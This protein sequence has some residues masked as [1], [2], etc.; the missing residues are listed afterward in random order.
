MSNHLLFFGTE[1]F[2]AVSLQALIDAGFSIATVVTK[3]DFR[4]GRKQLLTQPVVKKI[5]LAHNIPVLQP[6]KLTD[7]SEDLRALQPITGVLVSYGKIIPESIIN[8]CSPGIINV[9]PS[10]LPKYRGASPIESAI[11]HGDGKT[12]VSLMKLV[13]AM[14]AG[15]VYVQESVSLNGDENRP[16][17]YT[18]LAIVGSRLLINNLQKIIN[19]EILP[20][21]QD[22]SKAT[23]TQL[24]KKE[25]GILSPSVKTAVQLEREV[26]AYQGYP[27]C[28]YTIYNE[29][30]IVL[31]SR[32]A[33]DEED[34]QLIVACKDNT[35]LELLSLTGP[36]GRVMSGADFVRGYRK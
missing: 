7:I 15:P 26:R 27:K 25:D 20:V 11:L 34:G 13:A 31:A 4:R 35:W 18:Q 23:Y 32:I 24:L 12:G 5:A 10:E 22:E 21:P 9:H 17:L 8:L 29:E 14:D 16:S 6:N 30:C 28:R 1:D 36:S 33:K 19:N 2:S 3:P